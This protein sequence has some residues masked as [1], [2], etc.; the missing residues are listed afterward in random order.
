MVNQRAYGVEIEFLGASRRDVSD[1]LNRAGLDCE[2]EGYN[3]NTRDYWKVVTDASLRGESG[4][5]VSPI[6]KGA[7]GVRQLEIACN[8]LNSVAGVRVDRT[9]GLHIHLDSRDMTAAQIKTVF[10][11]YAD[12]EQQIDQIMPRSRRG[13][14]RWCGSLVDTKSTVQSTVNRKA[15][16]AHA[17]G[18][19]YKVNLT[20]VSNR[21]SIEFRQH[22]G[23]TEFAKIINWLNFLQQFTDR[24]VEL[25][26]TPRSPRIIRT[27]QRLY[28]QLRGS[29]ERN[30]GEVKWS[31]RQMAWVFIQGARSFTLTNEQ[32]AMLYRAGS[33]MKNVGLLDNWAY[34]I[35]TLGGFAPVVNHNVGE[36]ALTDGLDEDVQDWLQARAN[37][38]N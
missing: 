4:E 26:D 12:Y 6:L 37:E 3:H 32:I 21:G 17:I 13:N 31:R 14:P 5:L 25:N 22:S 1:A 36:D 27:K 38:L 16:L 34:L 9:C 30:G 23:T 18:R 28:G 2:V 7:D 29:F 33:P 24:S 20:N 8:A 11:R 10:T 19:Y 35:E 15:H